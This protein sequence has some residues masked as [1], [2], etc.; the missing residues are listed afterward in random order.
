MKLAR[1]AAEQ[2]DYIRHRLGLATD[3]DLAHTNMVKLAEETGE[4]A[5]A[6]LALYGLQRDAK[7]SGA[8]ADRRADLG[9]EIGDV[10]ATVAVLAHAVGLDIDQ[11]IAHRTK[12]LTMRTARWHERQA[13]RPP[14]QIPVVTQYASAELIDDIAYGGLNPASDPEWA[15]SGA[16]DVESYAT[17]CGKWC[18]MACLRMILLG[19]DGVSPTLWELLAGSY[20]Y[21]TYER[22][23][24]GSVGGMFYA[25]LVAYARETFGLEG[26]VYPDLPPDD[27]VKIAGDGRLVIASVHREIR[28]AGLVEPPAV[29]GHLVLVCGA[30]AERETIE[31][32]NPS[33]HHPGATAAV[34]PT[35]LFGRFYAGRGIAFA[36]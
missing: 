26:E 36:V 20:P 11:V 22:G 17:W 24:D 31:L 10:I 13:P 34:L 5:N 33:G 9:R 28:R 23:Q 15:V 32:R 35:G 2:A 27:L 16:P 7:L 12:E 4:V 30:D 3:T 1:F 14:L 29:G 18:G 6:F 25:P 19:R 8:E 21:G